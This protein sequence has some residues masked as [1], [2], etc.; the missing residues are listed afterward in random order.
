MNTNKALLKILP[1]RYILGE[2]FIPTK[3]LYIWEESRRSPSND[4]I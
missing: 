4:G 2:K 1:S 3:L